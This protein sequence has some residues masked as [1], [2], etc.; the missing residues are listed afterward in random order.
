[1]TEVRRLLP[2]AALAPFGGRRTNPAQLLAAAKDHDAWSVHSRS[3]LASAKFVRGAE[4]RPVLAYTV[5][6]PDTA[7]RLF[8]SGVR[9]VF[10]DHPGRLRRQ[11]E[12]AA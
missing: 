10:S 6:E 4:P 2:Q 5:N 11:L 9:G 1:L 3:S 12:D 7:W 8:E